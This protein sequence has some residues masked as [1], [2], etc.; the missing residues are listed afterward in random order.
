MYG[1][2]LPGEVVSR[3]EVMMGIDRIDH[4][5]ASYRGRLPSTR[6]RISPATPVAAAAPAT[7]GNV[8]IEMGIDPVE[9]SSFFNDGQPDQS[10]DENDEAEEMDGVDL[11]VGGMNTEI[12]PT[13]NRQ[14]SA[15]GVLG[16]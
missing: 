12:T 2:C 5:A 1:G 9:N 16:V 13:Q 15:V 4:T 11:A 7:P 14:P 6:S 10:D 8:A 3:D